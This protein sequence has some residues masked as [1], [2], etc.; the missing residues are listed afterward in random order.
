[1]RPFAASAQLVEFGSN[2][3]H[4]LGVIEVARVA[5]LVDDR[6]RLLVRLAPAPVEQDLRRK[7]PMYDSNNLAEEHNLEDELEPAEGEEGE[8]HE[9]H[10]LGP[11][12]FRDDPDED[13]ADPKYAD[14]L[15]L[16][17]EQ[18]QEELWCA[19]VRLAQE[20]GLY[21]PERPTRARLEAVEALLREFGR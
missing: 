13:V 14:E 15:E 18:L 3:I 7:S 11:E 12:Y 5:A 10:Y 6:R 4:Q 21:E 8:Y 16:A 2:G 19:L 1:M 20:G 17:L 9:P